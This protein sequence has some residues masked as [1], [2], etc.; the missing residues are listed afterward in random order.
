M[1][2]ANYS[3][4]QTAVGNWLNRADLTSYIPDI[5][6]L[7]EQRVYRDLRI[8]A[9]ETALSTA[10]SNGVLAVPNGYVEMKVAYVSGTPVTKLN[11]RSLEFMYENYPTRS[12]N[13]IPKFFAR[14]ASN[15]IFGPYP[16]SNYTIKGVYYARLTALSVSNTTNWFTTNAPD[17]LLW[18]SLAEAEVFLKNDDR[19]ALWEVKYQSAKNAVQAEDK[20]EN[21]SGSQPTATVSWK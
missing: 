18:A 6:M 17:V 16:D 8:R 21:F 13:G 10:I 9:M 2:I 19:T 11:R 20:A 5:I 1:S 15:F 4:L 12:A 14:E 7:G 3:E